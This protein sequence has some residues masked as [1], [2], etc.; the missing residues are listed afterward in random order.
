[1]EG[2]RRGVFPVEERERDGTTSRPRPVGG[3]PKGGVPASRTHDTPIV[4]RDVCP[5]G[6]TEVVRIDG[7]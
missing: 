7:V 1:M 4:Y 6:G 3:T 5:N 2:V